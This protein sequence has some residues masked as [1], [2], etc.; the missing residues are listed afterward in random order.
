MNQDTQRKRFRFG[1]RRG[2]LELDIILLNFFDACYDNLDQDSQLQ[3]QRL[4]ESPDPDLFA[5]LMSYQ[6]VPVPYQAIIERI[7]NHAQS[8]DSI[9]HQ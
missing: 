5:W 2:M 3:F 9:K 4:L 8:I 6:N 7:R 1:C